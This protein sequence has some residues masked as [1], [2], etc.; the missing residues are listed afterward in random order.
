MVRSLKTS[1]DLQ[2]RGALGRSLVS[3]RHLDC[4]KQAIKIRMKKKSNA[5]IVNGYTGSKDII[6][7]EFANKYGLLYNSV[8]TEVIPTS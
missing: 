1:R 7:N 5:A 4:W 2:I 6:A 8:R 3:H